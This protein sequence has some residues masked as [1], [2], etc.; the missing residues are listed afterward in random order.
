MFTNEMLCEIKIKIVRELISPSEK[1]LSLLFIEALVGVGKVS[2][3]GTIDK[4]HL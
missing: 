3:F 1:S 2:S 4:E